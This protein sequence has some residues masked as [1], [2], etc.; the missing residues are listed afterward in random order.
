[1]TLQFS[2]VLGALVLGASCA[3]F[4]GCASVR[5]TN[6]LFA[7]TQ[8]NDATVTRYQGRFSAR[9]MQGNAEQSAVGSFLWRE[10]GTDVQLELMS[11]LGQTMA[12]VSQNTQGATL[13]LPNQPP[14]RAPEVDTLMQDALGFSLPVSGLRDWLRARPAPGTPARVARDAQSRPETI[15]QNGWT[16]HYVA[17][18][19]DTSADARIR[20]LD[21]DR[22]Q[23]TGTNGPLTVR[24]VLDQ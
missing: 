14:R 4:A 21:L 11:P 7:G 20:R 16:V 1:M 17:W 5:P 2:R 3:L 22:Q 15:E 8:D 23:S 9:Y 19:D 6:D 13:E 24:L 10:R 18:T 12:V